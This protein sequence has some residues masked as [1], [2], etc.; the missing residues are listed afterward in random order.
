MLS[1]ELCIL[2][3]VILESVHLFWS[4]DVN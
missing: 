1:M 3:V 2:I 4:M